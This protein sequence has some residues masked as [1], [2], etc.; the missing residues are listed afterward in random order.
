[1][2]I[3]LEQNLYSDIGPLHMCKHMRCMKS[4]V[5]VIWTPKAL[6]ELKVL[7]LGSV[8]TLILSCKHYVLLFVQHVQHF[9][10]L[11]FRSIFAFI[12]IKKNISMLDPS[13]LASSKRQLKNIFP[14]LPYF[15]T[16]KYK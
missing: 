9:G 5:V 6:I 10:A 7:I 13:L 3:L 1:M 4:T 11:S 8:K 2:K 15:L 16:N 14:V 12:S